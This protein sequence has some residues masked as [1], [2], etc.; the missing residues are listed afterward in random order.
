[1]VLKRRKKS[2]VGRRVNRVDGQNN[3]PDGVSPPF[4]ELR[5][6]APDI[7]AAICPIQ[8]T[9]LELAFPE[10]QLSRTPAKRGGVSTKGPAIIRREPNGF[11]L[12][13]FTA[14]D[15][16]NQIA[17]GEKRK[18]GRSLSSSGMVY[19]IEGRDFH[20]RLMKAERV[21]IKSQFQRIGNLQG[22]Q[23][24]FNGESHQ[25]HFSLPNSFRR[26]FAQLYYFPSL[27][28]TTE[29]N[30]F[31]PYPSQYHLSMQNV[32]G[33]TLVD[34]NINAKNL[35][36]HFE[37]RVIEMLRFVSPG[38]PWPTAA[39]L[40]DDNSAEIILWRVPQTGSSEFPPPVQPFAGSPQVYP[41]MALRYLERI[42][43][44]NK[45]QFTPEGAWL[46]FMRSG[47]RGGSIHQRLLTMCVAIEGVLQIV[48]DKFSLNE[49]IIPPSKSIVS[50]AVEH[51]KNWSCTKGD[52]AVK[53]RIINWI[54]SGL[55]QPRRPKDILIFLQ[56]QKLVHKPH[57]DAW[58]KARNPT[59][60]ARPVDIRRYAK[61]H[62][63]LVSLVYRLIFQLIGYKG[64]FTEYAK[65]GWP[66]RKFSPVNIKKPHETADHHNGSTSQL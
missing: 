26:T 39:V 20:G 40:G 25:L 46:E 32:S 34:V 27:G 65:P 10:L 61:A 43:V 41:S 58:G 36:R 11:V 24:L 42:V 22:K 44:F 60:H 35:P 21:F 8:Q 5:N 63:L 57:L 12:T 54:R 64:P 38:S 56:N 4:E 55:T 23:G 45:P 51:M 31:P 7:Y 49:H 62:P 1:M 50:C 28:L 9:N 29:L 37:W 33:G 66:S 13:L 16:I 3:T 2:A 30:A 18:V 15:E 52:E 14:G 48:V 59:T 47:H 19:R 6:L 53:N 17:S